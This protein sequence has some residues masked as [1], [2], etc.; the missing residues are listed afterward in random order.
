MC[1]GSC[2]ITDHPYAQVCVPN[3]VKKYEC[4]SI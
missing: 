4:K 2:K 1:H 3:K